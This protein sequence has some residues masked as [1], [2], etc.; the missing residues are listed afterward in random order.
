[1]SIFS[2]VSGQKINDG[3]GHLIFSPN[4]GEAHKQLFQDTLN[5]HESENLV[6]TWYASFSHSVQKKRYTLCGG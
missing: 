1:M 2:Q 3:K 6:C 4:T 5:I